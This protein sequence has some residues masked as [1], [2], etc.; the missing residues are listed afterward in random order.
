[1]FRIGK[2]LLCLTTQEHQC[3]DLG[4]PSLTQQTLRHA[5]SVE[6]EV[7]RQAVEN[8]KNRS[9]ANLRGIQR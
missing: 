4:L 7:S 1:M 8:I 9:G 5:H 2:I 3:S 6:T